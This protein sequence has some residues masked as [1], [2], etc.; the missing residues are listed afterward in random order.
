MLI[1]RLG[2]TALGAIH[3]GMPPPC[4]FEQRQNMTDSEDTC[5]SGVSPRV[6][7]AAG[8]QLAELL[9]SP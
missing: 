1:A 4:V 2:L 3:L 7:S 9:L 8:M 6:F 5:L